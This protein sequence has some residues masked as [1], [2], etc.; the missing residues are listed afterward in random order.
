MKSRF[1]VII[2]D[3]IS[4]TALDRLRRIASVQL[5]CGADRETLLDA[6]AQ[7]D[8][9]IVRS[10]TPVDEPLL[11]RA[12]CLKVIGRAGVGLEHIDLNAAAAQGV[13]V[14]HT[15]HAS[16][17]AVAELAVG[18]ILAIERRIA[19]SDL[20][21]R[22]CRFHQARRDGLGRAVHG[23][24]LGIVGM[25]RIGST[26]AR[27]A[28]VGF[29]MKILYNDIQNVGPFP[30]PAEP[31]EK[32]RLFAESDV[33]SLHVPL[34]DQTRN[35]LDAAAFARFKPSATLINTARGPVVDTNA[36]VEALRAG[37]LAG[38]GLDVTDPEPL[39]AGHALLDDPRVVL[40]PHLGARTA[41]AQQ[42]M[43]HVVD[44]VI[45]V[46]TGRPPNFPAT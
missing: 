42:A 6:V 2:A 29:G 4:E 40:T 13:V 25:G 11:N 31:A 16:T 33:I 8:A 43:D 36:L 21:V 1:R 39:P 26:L 37:T 24:T 5:L 9:L 17:Q 41:Q 14:V 35:L 19:R 20:A 28:S 22:Q 30:F 7:A 23:L 38:A 45:A 46:L 44:D 3:P 32:T 34:T 15:P 27:L 10:E 12:K 18:L